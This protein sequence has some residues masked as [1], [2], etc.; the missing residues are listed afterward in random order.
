[1]SKEVKQKVFLLPRG[2]MEKDLLIVR[3]KH[4]RTNIDVI[5][6]LDPSN[7]LYE[8]IRYAE[9]ISSWFIG[10][11]VSDD[12]SLYFLTVTDPLFFILSYANQHPGKFC[13]I[14]DLLMDENYP[15]THILSKCCSDEEL[16]NIFDFKSLLVI[17]SLTITRQKRYAGCTR[18]LKF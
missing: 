1:M 6:A 12:G 18:N 16:R 10:E 8:V 14:E 3:L 9:D 2:V 7:K 5:C 15:D 17:K 11:S 13:P 4:P